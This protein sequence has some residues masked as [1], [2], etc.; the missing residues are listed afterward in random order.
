M[1]LEISNFGK[2]SVMDSLG[3][4]S[5]EDEKRPFTIHATG[6]A[7]I[8]QEKYSVITASGLGLSKVYII[9]SYQDENFSPS[10]FF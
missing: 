7:F 1:P 9:V 2:K 6:E 5:S 10:K 3:H 8:G 4:F